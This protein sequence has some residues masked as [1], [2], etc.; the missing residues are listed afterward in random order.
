MLAEIITIGDEI[1]IGQ[2]VDTNSAWLG[3][4][5]SNIGVSVKQITSVSDDKQHILEALALAEK[6]ADIIIMTGGLGP[7]KD[8]ITKHT[9]REYFKTSMVINEDVL[10][11]VTDFFV[12]RNRPMLEVNNKQ[13][14]VLANCEV[15]FNKQGTAPGMWI[16][17]N[18]KV[19]ISMPGVPF[20]MKGIMM[21]YGLDKLK[22][23]F[24]LPF[25]YHRTILTQGLGESF[26]ADKIKDWEDSLA[27]KQI[28]L[29]YLPSPG[30]V[31][32]R[33]TAKGTD[34]QKLKSTVDA[35]VDE[36]YKLLNENIYGEEELG[37]TAP[38]F[39]SIIGKNLT[40]KNK[41][42]SI[43]ESCTGGYIS[44]LITSI[45]GSS[46]YYKGSIIAYENEIK[47]A[48]LDV[49]ADTLKNFGA[50]SIECAKEMA[51][52]ILKK[53]NTDYAIATTG[54]A[55][56][57]GETPDKPIGTVCIAIATKTDI[58]AQKFIF[59]NDRVRNIHMAAD[60]AL[61]MLNK[62]IK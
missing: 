6:R 48:E 12:K 19:F 39:Q 18:N 38:T 61:N 60:M 46:A 26:L 50:V 37:K 59:G 31:K 22:Q 36:L 40:K 55:G 16:K 1:L 25:I 3:T 32:L 51:A 57:T 56:P 7:T 53:F 15:L 62:A 8:D 14:E 49:H 58:T 45:A 35:E 2:I 28:K 30:M 29:A 24:T 43:A 27:A 34:K 33:L 47:M 5:L 10:K 44:H 4:K 42:I 20:E 11:H 23:T 54:I 13:A 9:L 52:G 41:T 17:H 21:D